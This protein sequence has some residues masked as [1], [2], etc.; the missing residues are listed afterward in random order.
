[1]TDK[2][3]AAVIAGTQSKSPRAQTQ[4]LPAEGEYKDKVKSF[5]VRIAKGL[6]DILSSKGEKSTDSYIEELSKCS[7]DFTSTSFE[8]TGASMSPSNRIFITFEP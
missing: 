3:Q 2:N 7:L 1:M 5:M 4:K 8:L 6:K